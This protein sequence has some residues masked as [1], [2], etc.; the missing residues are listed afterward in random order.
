MSKRPP[1]P[2]SLIKNTKPSKQTSQ[3]SNNMPLVLPPTFKPPRRKYFMNPSTSLLTCLKSTDVEC[4]Q[5]GVEILCWHGVAKTSDNLMLIQEDLFRGRFEE[6]ERKV[7]EMEKEEKGDA[8]GITKE[9]KKAL[10]KHKN[11]SNIGPTIKSLISSPNRPT[12]LDRYSTARS[13]LLPT[14]STYSAPHLVPFILLSLK[15]SDLPSANLA[16]KIL[17]KISPNVVLRHAPAT[18][19]NLSSIFFVSPPTSLE[20]IFPKPTLIELNDKGLIKYN[21]TLVGGIIEGARR[22]SL[23]GDQEGSKHGAVLIS[24]NNKIISLGWNHR[25]TV[26]VNSKKVRKKVIHAEVHAILRAE[27]DIEG[28]TIFICESGGGKY[29][30]AH[31]CPNCNNVLTK[32]GI[33]QAIYTVTTGGLGAWAYNKNQN[34]DAPT[35]ETARR[36]RTWRREGGEKVLEELCRMCEE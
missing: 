24:K 4:L 14:L 29:E 16:L 20:T 15:F 3:Q 13:L 32:L 22:V 7:M 27:E 10:S 33:K 28:S 5:K 30:T 8:K 2:T 31:P 9:E 12:Q 36:E 26:P 21:P 25:Y 17:E 23:L 1:S 34:V 19:P 35:W 18:S 11:P 6:V